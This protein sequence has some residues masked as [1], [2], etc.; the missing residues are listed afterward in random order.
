MQKPPSH[1]PE[2]YECPF[3]RLVRGMLTA[4]SL[5]A[6]SDIVLRTEIVTAFVSP[7]WWSRNPGHVLVVPN[8]HHENLYTIHLGDLSA[9]HAASQRIALALKSAYGC[10]GVSIRQHNEPSG[11]QDVWHYHLHVFPRYAGDDLYRSEDKRQTSPQERLPYAER[12]RTALS[13]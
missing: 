3:C 9:V 13:E 7:V 11:N 1:T 5:N 6:A 10:D 12:L 2:G 8:A 4:E